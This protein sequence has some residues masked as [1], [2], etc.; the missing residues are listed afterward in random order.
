LVEGVEVGRAA[1]ENPR[2]QRVRARRKLF[3]GIVTAPSRTSRRS[4]HERW[5]GSSGDHT[6]LAERATL[7]RFRRLAER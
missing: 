7:A 1:S 4:W 2:A 5:S 3:A 6:P